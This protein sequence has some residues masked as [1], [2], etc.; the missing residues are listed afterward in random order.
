[1]IPVIYI[2]NAI[3]TRKIAARPDS[4]SAAPT[5]SRLTIVEKVLLGLGIVE[6]PFGIDKYLLIQQEHSEMGSIGGFVVSITSLCLIG[7][8]AIWFNAISKRELTPQRLI[9]GIPL[10]IYLCAVAI[11]IF[12]AENQTLVLCDLFLVT[13]AYALFFYLAN[14]VRNYQDIVFVVCC[15]AFALV[16]Q[17]L[18]MIGLKAAGSAMWGRRVD[19]G[20]IPFSVSTEGRTEGTLLSPVV[21]GSLMAL[22]FLVPLPLFISTKSRLIWW[23]LGC[24]LAIGLV[25]LMFTQTRGAILSVILGTAMVAGGMFSRGWLPRWTLSTAIVGF[26]VAAIPLIGVIQKRIV[27]GD[28]G[29]AESRVHLSSIALATIEKNPILG[30]GA[31]NCHIACLEIASSPPFRSEWYYTIHCKYLVVWVETGLIGLLAFLLALGNGVRYGFVAW[32]R[33]SPFLSPLGLG[34]AAAVLGHSV[35]MFV[36][37]FNSRAQVQMLW[38]LFGLLACLYQQTSVSTRKLPRD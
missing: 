24:S 32:M 2:V 7:L 37:I 5:R 8:Y 11:S 31:G 3:K 38:V 22:M 27:E 9:F 12:S 20:P 33:R 29:S 4:P 18:V 1:L 14:R 25:G 15:F 17:G 16:L 30:H 36:D 13:Q 6:I 26:L 28:E 35:H 19:I 23:F 34:C 21:A 10:V